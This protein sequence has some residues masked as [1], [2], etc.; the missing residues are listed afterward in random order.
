MT[1]VRC[2]HDPGRTLS[3]G[4]S[5]STLNLSP[6]VSR[7]AGQVYDVSIPDG[8]DTEA[9][10][11]HDL[12]VQPHL[13]KALNRMDI[14]MPTAV[15]SEALPFTLAGKNHCIIQSETGTG[16]TLTF[17][18]PAIEDP[19]PALTTLILVPTRELAVQ[20]HYQAAQLVGQRKNSKRV[21]A[22]FSGTGSDDQLSEYSELKPHIL[23]GTPR[24]IQELLETNHRDFTHLRRLVLDEADKILLPLERRAHEKKRILRESHPRPGAVVVR[25]ILSPHRGR[26]RPKH[27][28]LQLIC[29]SATVTTSLQEEL[30]DLGWGPNADFISTSSLQKLVSPTAI[31]HQYV[32]VHNADVD[33]MDKT[34]ALFEHFHASR[35]KSALVFIHRG[36]S[37]TQFVDDLNNR[38]VSSVALYSKAVNPTEYASFLAD[39]E[40][41]RISLV[42]GTEETVRGL[43]FPWLNM[44]YISEV[45]R[46]ASEYLHLCGRVGRL[47]RAG[48]AVVF[49]DGDQ[50]VRRL[51]QHYRMLGVKGSQVFL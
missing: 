49:V 43:D 16:K 23:I 44:V 39:F 32:T 2:V 46:S 10:T 42:V 5:F 13:C 3:Q 15:Q 8:L 51:L 22:M 12:G 9:A 27:S 26:A 20:M 50:Q 31:K 18:L 28:R 40:S 14:T 33:G 11:F 47:G 6:F 24:R 21:M 36:A 30:E 29:T 45:P 35:E 38:G 1:C 17:L 4:V 41:G 48:R 7:S 37:V 34:E 25:K 19:L